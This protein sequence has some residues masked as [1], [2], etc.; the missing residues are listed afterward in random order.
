D[1][2]VGTNLF[3]IKYRHSDPETAQKVAN[4]LAEVFANNNLDRATVNSTKA[5]DLLAREI[6][7]MQARV[8]HDTEALFNYAKEHNL[9]LTNDTTLNTEAQRLA[10]LT[11]QLF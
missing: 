1:G 6:A 7:D 2:I 9:P 5:T 4:T 8:R 10:D 3:T 11:R